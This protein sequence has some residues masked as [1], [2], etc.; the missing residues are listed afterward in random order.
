MCWYRSQNS[1]RHTTRM[2]SST[3]S[4]H[5]RDVHTVSVNHVNRPQIHDGME[6]TPVHVHL[7]GNVIGTSNIDVHQTKRNGC[8]KMAVADRSGGPTWG[9]DANGYYFLYFLKIHYN[10][11]F[12][13]QS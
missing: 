2:F 12:E 7:I 3:Q 5:V 6:E 4:S 10:K 13:N 8:H 9:N 1:L 11:L